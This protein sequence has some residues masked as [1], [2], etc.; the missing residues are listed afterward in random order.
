MKKSLTILAL[1]LSTVGAAHA[2][3]LGVQGQLFPLIE[4]DIRQTI[5]GEVAKADM[6][7]V[8]KDLTESVDRYFD[9]FP[10]RVLPS[11]EQTTTHYIDPSITVPDDIKAPVQGADGDYHWTVLYAKGTRVNPLEKYRPI[12]AM[13]YFDGTNEDQLK[14]VEQ[15]VAVNGRV[16]PVETAGANIRDVSKR[17]DR[18]VFYASEDMMQ[19]F[20]VKH[21]PALLY[22]GSG[23]YSLYLGMTEFAAPYKPAE[24]NAVWSPTIK[25]T[26]PSIAPVPNSVSEQDKDALRNLVDSSLKAAHNVEEQ[27]K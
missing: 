18:P 16:I 23:E 24:V 3:D 5:M 22:P 11:I 26:D 7:K 21:L 4:I 15:T 1:A 17:L 20:R 25:A 13:L 14:F 8:Q 6:A 27:Q 9:G 19:R 10:K 2:H 12:T